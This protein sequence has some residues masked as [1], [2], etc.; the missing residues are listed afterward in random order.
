MRTQWEKAMS[1]VEEEAP[2]AR[3]HLE[4]K[5]SGSTT[6]ATTTSRPAPVPTQPTR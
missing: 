1:K 6:G 2:K 5:R 3:Q 4:A